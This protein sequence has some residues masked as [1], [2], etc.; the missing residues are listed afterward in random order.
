[1]GYQLPLHDLDDLLEQAP[2]LNDQAD[3]LKDLWRLLTPPSAPM[4][5][6]ALMRLVQLRD[7]LLWRFPYICE[8]EKSELTEI[9]GKMRT[10]TGMKAPVMNHRGLQ[11]AFPVWATLVTHQA[12]QQNAYTALHG[13]LVIL[14]GQARYKTLITEFGSLIRGARQRTAG[15][16]GESLYEILNEVPWNENPEDFFEGLLRVRERIAAAK[17]RFHEILVEDLPSILGWRVAKKEKTESGFSWGESQFHTDSEEESG[18]A[19]VGFGTEVRFIKVDVD[20]PV[21][22]L[23]AAYIKESQSIDSGNPLFVQQHVSS[24]QAG[25]AKGLANWLKNYILE[26][27]SSSSYMLT[28]AAI[29]ATMLAT[30]RTSKQ[31]A[32]VLKRT[33]QDYRGCLPVLELANERL[34][35]NILLPPSAYIAKEEAADRLIRTS[36]EMRLPLPPSYVKLIKKWKILTKGKVSVNSADHIYPVLDRVRGETGIDYTEGRIRNILSTQVADLSGDPM[37]AIWITGNDARHSLGPSHYCVLSHAKLEKNYVKATWSIFN[38][39]LTF[40]DFTEGFVGAHNCVLD[41]TVKKGIEKLW[42]RLHDPRRGYSGRKGIAHIHNA[43]VDHLTILLVMLTGHRPNSKV[44][45][46]RRWDFDLQLGA[47]VYGCKQMDPAHFYRPVALGRIITEQLVVYEHHI[48]ALLDKMKKLKVERDCIKQVVSSLNG[49]RQWFFYLDQNLQIVEDGMKRWKSLFQELFPDLPLNIGRP[50][51]ARK[52]RTLKGSSPEFAYLQLGHHAIIGYPYSREAPTSIYEMAKRVGPVIDEIV[53]SVIGRKRKTLGLLKRG[54]NLVPLKLPAPSVGICCWTASFKEAEKKVIEHRRRQRHFRRKRAKAEREKAKGLFYKVLGR[55]HQELADAIKKHLDNGRKSHGIDE[56]FR[57][58]PLEFKELLD[59]SSRISGQK[60]LLTSELIGLRNYSHYALSKAKKAGFY[61]GPIPDA[62]IELPTRLSTEFIPGMLAAAETMRRLRS[63]FFDYCSA[64]TRELDETE[65]TKNGWDLAYLASILIVYGGVTHRSRLEQM[66]RNSCQVTL[67]PVSKDGILVQYSQNPPKVWGL[68]RAA[69]YNYLKMQDSLVSQPLLD[70]VSRALSYILPTE[71]VGDLGNKSLLDCLLETARVAQ[72][73]ELSGL[74]RAST[75]PETGSWSLPLVRQI[76]WLKN[77]DDPTPP[78]EEEVEDNYGVSISRAPTIQEVKEIYERLRSLI[79]QAYRDVKNKDGAIF[80]PYEQHRRYR[81]KVVREVQQL[82][83]DSDVPD[84]GKAL[85]EWLCQMLMNKKGKGSYTLAEST[86]YNYFTTVGSGLLAALPETIILELDDEE[87]IDLYNAAVGKKPNKT[88][89]ATLREL[90]NLH[91]VL[92]KKYGAPA[93][94]WNKIEGFDDPLPG[95]V[96]AQVV[97]KNEARGALHALKEWAFEQ[98]DNDTTGQRQLR[99]GYLVLVLLMATG[100]RIS[101]IV[102]LQNRDIYEVSGRLYIRVRPN[103]GRGVKSIAAKRVIDISDVA[104]SHEKKLLIGWKEAEKR[105]LG[106]AWKMTGAFFNDIESNRPLS[107]NTVTMILQSALSSGS[108]T[109][110]SSHHIRHA[111]GGRMQ[112][113]FGTGNACK[114]DFRADRPVSYQISENDELLLPRN[115]KRYQCRI[116]HASAVTTN[117]SYGH[118]PW[119]FLHSKALSWE[120]EISSKGR[121]RAIGKSYEAYRKRMSR[122]G[123]FFW[124]NLI[125]RAAKRMGLVIESGVVG[126]QEIK[127]PD[128]GTY[129][130]LPSGANYLM[131]CAPSVTD[132]RLGAHEDDYEVYGLTFDEARRLWKSAKEIAQTTGIAFFSKH[133]KFGDLRSSMVP[134]IVHGSDKVLNLLRNH[135][136]V[137]KD[138]EHIVIFHSASARRSKRQEIRL[139]SRLAERLNELINKHC[140]GLILSCTPA[141]NGLY[142]C[143]LHGEGGESLNHWLAWVIAILGVISYQQKMP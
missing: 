110:L 97:L 60:E 131:A 62:K 2:N 102:G 35:Q 100:C 108:N 80:V 59:P 93:I 116:G 99:Q 16:R 30:G 122:D 21:A 83:Q 24:L 141:K 54:E 33:M 67:N 82:I 65:L 46:L 56:K 19:H 81:A 139:T 34:V 128:V 15:S 117:R 105:R 104:T 129:L 74:A 58:L 69:A 126:Y 49:E 92:V 123:D 47:A 63:S 85:G 138:I 111:I 136:A 130:G 29:L 119:V 114:E 40:T 120:S 53:N 7:V 124:F 118:T 73:V 5:L 25:E 1:M 57:L 17:P 107:R 4:L 96:D 121:A 31:S 22:S 37:Q 38:E 51:L 20:R 71:L 103:Y 14:A 133:A 45:E 88:K 72:L 42:S 12:P 143:T 137:L 26:E 95:A 132:P 13:L 135:E 115:I 9:I 101:E 23:R 90:Q 134:T 10:V 70:G 28:G 98:N 48:T 142:L 44:F 64:Y 11:R 6:D 39:S 43:L 94:E 41:E 77:A 140:K 18:R 68:W 78:V 52:M 91:A 3:V 8:L 113:Y 89:K 55:I 32:L 79:P 127:K 87:Y 76:A 66:L 27:K 36:E 84:L 50:F 125:E 109:R 86:I 75:D 106:R 61:L 112:I